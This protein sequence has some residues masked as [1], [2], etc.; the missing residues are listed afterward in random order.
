M[1]CVR[2]TAAQ[3]MAASADIEAGAASR[4]R[5][6]CALGAHFVAIAPP[7]RHER[8]PAT[9]LACRRQ[10]H[11]RAAGRNGYLK[12]Q[13]AGAVLLHRLHPRV[14]FAFGNHDRVVLGRLL[15]LCVVSIGAVHFALWIEVKH[16]DGHAFASAGTGFV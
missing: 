7:V 16:F 9:Q 15:R 14:W 12:P 6:L 11:R 4:A 1:L 13:A 5:M 8:E 10:R 3:P 2:E